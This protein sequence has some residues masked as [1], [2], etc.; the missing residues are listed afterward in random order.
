MKPDFL[1]TYSLCFFYLILAEHIQSM[2]MWEQWNNGPLFSKSVSETC[3][4]LVTLGVS[5]FAR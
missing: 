1:G 4:L 2:P 3:R 5:G